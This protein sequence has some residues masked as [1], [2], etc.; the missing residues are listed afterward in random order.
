[1]SSSDKGSFGCSREEAAKNGVHRFCQ[2]GSVGRG[3]VFPV[4]GLCQENDM[5]DK[6]VR[7]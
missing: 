1:M 5:Y 3:R 7:G 4:R 6:E 2:P